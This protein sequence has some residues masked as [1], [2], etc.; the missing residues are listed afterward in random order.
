LFEEKQEQQQQQQRE[1]KQ[2]PPEHGPDWPPWLQDAARPNSG[3]AAP[4]ARSG[5][6]GEVMDADAPVEAAADAMLAAWLGLPQA[7]VSALLKQWP[8]LA[9]QTW[10]GWQEQVEAAE[11][12]LSLV[13]PGWAQQSPAGPSGLH[14][15][16]E[17]GRNGGRS[18]SPG[19]DGAAVMSARGSGQPHLGSDST[20]MGAPSAQQA[21]EHGA[22]ALAGQ[23]PG[24]IAP[25][26]HVA[27]K[28]RDLLAQPGLH[29][30]AAAALAAAANL[31]PFSASLW[32]PPRRGAAAA[33]GALLDACPGA[34]ASR[35]FVPRV[36]WL[37]A[38][39]AA[40]PE[41]LAELRALPLA[42]LA[43]A[44]LAPRCAYEVFQY[45]VAEKVPRPWPCAAARLLMRT[46]KWSLPPAFKAANPG[47]VA[48]QAGMRDGG[49]GGGGAPASE[50]GAATRRPSRAPL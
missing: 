1:H 29:P 44:P 27:Q 22:T 18:G 20:L 9:V 10:A 48:W 45:L 19:R 34:W 39:A 17:L 11:D 36:R 30:A 46:S 24:R 32:R 28:A 2:Q 33:A 3:D 50:S 21:F 25:C 13:R 26:Q 5:G 42:T 35:S 49:A 6:M 12:L 14:S 41:L 8:Q 43:H 23:K 40:S 38:L 47:F 15:E 31:A 37:G 7:R 4:V 16:A